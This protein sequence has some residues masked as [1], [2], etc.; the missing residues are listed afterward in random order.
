MNA[1]RIRASRSRK[2]PV[3]EGYYKEDSP[4][5]MRRLQYDGLPYKPTP[6]LNPLANFGRRFSDDDDEFTMTMGDMGHEGGVKKRSF[7][8][9]QDAPE[10]S[11]VRTESPL[12]EPR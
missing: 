10:V 8:I 6:T 9:F 5:E 2:T 11:P 3:V 4:P 7:N 12:E 1:P